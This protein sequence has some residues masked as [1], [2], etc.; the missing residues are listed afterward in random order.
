MRNR[1]VC[2][3][4]QARAR[5]LREAGSSGEALRGAGFSLPELAPG[6]AGF[7]LGELRSLGF[8][9]SELR[10][11]VGASLEERRDFREATFS[12]QGRCCSARKRWEPKVTLVA[13]NTVQI[14]L[15]GL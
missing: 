13:Y 4:K 5:E 3:P 10:D 8:L 12:L 15:S 1:S 6:S 2:L 9:A 7:S 11:V 14:M